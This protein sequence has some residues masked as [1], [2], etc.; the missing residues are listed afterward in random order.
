M[1]P[2]PFIGQPSGFLPPNQQVAYTG[3][4]YSAQPPGNVAAQAEPE[5]PQKSAKFGG[6]KNTVGYSNILVVPSLTG[7]HSNS[8]HM[9]Q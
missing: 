3:G 8:L 9:L 1:G 7:P 6:M 2:P 4:P 5:Q